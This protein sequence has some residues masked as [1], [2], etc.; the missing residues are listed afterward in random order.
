CGFKGDFA[1]VYVQTVPL[2]HVS[3]DAEHL[4]ASKE[5]IHA[6]GERRKHCN[7]YG[8]AREDYKACRD[9]EPR[10]VGPISVAVSGL[11]YVFQ[12]D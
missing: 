9:S 5:I 3:P 6:M 10:S 7:K 4:P 12:Q 8:D 2:M 11:F 1:S